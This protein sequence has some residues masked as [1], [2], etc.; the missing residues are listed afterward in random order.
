MNESVILCK[1]NKR[2]AKLTSM[3]PPVPTPLA[4]PVSS[5]IEPEYF[6]RLPEH[7]PVSLSG[8]DVLDSEEE[9]LPGDPL[10]TNLL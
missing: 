2:D 7:S 4:M 10:G 3:R 6:S 1:T 9:T 8:I 5:V